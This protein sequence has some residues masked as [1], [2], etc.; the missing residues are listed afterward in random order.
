MKKH[1]LIIISTL[2]ISH[3][4]FAKEYGYYDP[5][6]ILLV[7][8][9]DTGE[10]YNLDIQSL[11]K[12]VNDLSAHAKNYPPRF[13]TEEEK[14]RAIKDTQ[15]LSGML[16]IL[17]SNPDASPDLLKRSGLVNSIGHNL[18]IPDAAQKADRDFKKLLAQRPDDP[19]GNFM[20]G[21]FLGGANQGRLALP[22]LEKAASLGFTDAYF[23][24]GMAYLTQKNADLA[25]KNFEIYK[26]HNPDDQSVIQIMEAIKSGNIQFKTK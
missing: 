14:Q 11:D 1:L 26:S 3:I 24:L 25:L 10:K 7:T 21:A 15:M 17:V 20:Y 9:S 8:K 22:Y 13:E 23:S 5:K 16:E 6:T 19:V 12:I 2:L 18:D 4:C